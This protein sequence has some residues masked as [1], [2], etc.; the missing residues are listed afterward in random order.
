M[1]I[2]IPISAQFD[3]AD[4]KKQIQIINDQIKNL[5]NEVSL[6]Q[7]KKFEPITLKSKE[8][9]SAFINQ[10]QKLLKIQTELQQ[11]LGA[12]GQKNPFTADWS[13]MYGDKATRIE[14]MMNA[15]QFMGV[16]FEDHPTPKPKPPAPAPGGGGNPPAN[17]PAPPGNRPPPGGAPGWANGW[18]QQ[19][20]GVLGSGLNA[21]GPVGGIFNNALRSGMSGGAGAGLMG[22]VG[23]LAAL[24]VGKLIGAIANKIDKAQDAAIGMDK[25]YRQIGGI[26][27][28]SHVKSAV[29]G[30]SNQLGMDVSEGIGLGSTYA[31][32]AN[33][34]AGDNLATGMLISGGMA[35]TYG[36]DPN[37]AAAIMGG[38]RGS[39]IARNDQDTKRIGLVIGETIAKSNA[40][41]K[42]DELM[43]AVSQFAVSQARQSLSAPNI[44]GYGGAMSSLMGMNLPGLDVG[45]SAALISRVNAALMGGGAMGDASQMLTA[46]VGAHYG[47]NPFQLRQM[48]EAGMFATKGQVLGG[49]GDQ[50]YFS[51]TRDTLR[52]NYR[53]GSDDYYLAMANHL[54]TTIAQARALD[55]MDT[56]QI[57]G[58]SERMSRLGLD[59]SKVNATSIGT[60]GQIESGRGLG[61]LAQGYLNAKGRESLSKGE[62]ADLLSALGGSDPEKLKDV[63]TTIASKH[64]TV[65]TEGSQIRDGIAELN[66]NFTKFSDNALPALNVMRMAMVKL[67]GGSEAALRRSYEATEMRER[68]GAIGKKYQGQLEANQAARDKLIA[69]GKGRQTP[70]GYKEFTRLDKER[71]D[72]LAKQSSD[73]DAARKEAHELA[74]GPS[75]PAEAA[76]ATGGADVSG[77]QAVAAAEVGANGGSSGGSSLPAGAGPGGNVSGG[78]V[79]NL[80]DPHGGWQRFKGAREGL[81]GMAGQL[82]RYQSKA[83]FG[84]QKTLRQL[85]NTYAPSSENN[86]SLYVSQVA[87][88]TGLNPDAD[89]DL[90]DPQTMRKVLEAMVRKENGNKGLSAAAGHYD[91]AIGDAMAT[92][93][94]FSA[95]FPS[96]VRL[97]V[98][99]NGPWG[100]KTA[101][102][103]MRPYKQQRAWSNR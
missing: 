11:K 32:A 13:K 86:T 81:A 83:K 88:W 73:L 63:L 14:K 1:A 80:R 46:R 28:Y 19:G 79:G 59:L 40:F 67:T 84:H 70:E 87:K 30:V 34:R 15:L 26:A 71:A 72:I 38:F 92:S 29:Y 93:R 35:R 37:S 56:G 31:R 17:P 18:G 23:G 82:L 51:M 3:A 27:S 61:G 41:A 9:L 7:N 49:Q 16:E 95:E 91:E 66:N 10:M 96:E 4:V 45:G 78:N 69:Q 97:A 50:S 42:A 100:T 99:V 22:L 12:T 77:S 62:R 76:G 5:S 90:R 85:I 102:H 20:M 36:M 52:R 24:G 60:I 64:G 98:D 94:N 54:G 55:K 25:I 57:S 48:R 2:K 33:M 6:A 44:A 103:T 39:N 89:I 68:A 74:Y 43:Q 21:M 53:A 58:A 47:M 75:T 8:D 101:E 65:Q